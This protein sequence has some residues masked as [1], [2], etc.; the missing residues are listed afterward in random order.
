MEKADYL[1]GPDS[2]GSQQGLIHWPT[3]EI[4]VRRTST[5]ESLRWLRVG[6]TA[7]FLPR[8][9]EGTFGDVFL[10]ATRHICSPPAIHPSP[11]AKPKE[12]R[13]GVQERA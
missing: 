4:L 10:R 6:F 7:T 8:L 5:L 3:L 9:I 1:Q 2:L 11:H 12:G 13:L